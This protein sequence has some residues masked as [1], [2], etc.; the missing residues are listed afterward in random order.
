MVKEITE[1]YWHL[2][3]P[4]PLL[5]SVTVD[6]KCF[7]R[8]QPSLLHHLG[9]SATPGKSTRSRQSYELHW[10]SPILD[11]RSNPCTWTLSPKVAPC[12]TP[13]QQ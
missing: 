3:D 7:H 5:L 12:H 9:H 10:L 8:L 4:G 11:P 6:Q 2:K 13:T 1:N